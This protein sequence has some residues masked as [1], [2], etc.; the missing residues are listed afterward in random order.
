VRIT[1]PLILL[2]LTALFVPGVRAQEARQGEELALR[3]DSGWTELVVV[4]RSGRRVSYAR[5]DIAKVE[6]V[7]PRSTGVGTSTGGAPASL[8]SSGKVFACEARD[9][10]RV[11]P[12]AI[13][14]TSYT[15]ASGAI[16]GELT[17]KTLSSVHR[18]RGKLSGSSMSF[19]EVEA[20]R[21]GGAHL[22][23]SYALTLSPGGANG[24]YT[25]HNDNSRGTYAITIR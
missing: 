1:A 20:I 21:P 3:S 9:G 7:V 5:A 8:L 6:Y 22:N 16:V 14:I 24:T 10:G 18:I 4:L 23:V 17:W 25:D 19:T 15:A 2:S 13:R 11:W 12:C